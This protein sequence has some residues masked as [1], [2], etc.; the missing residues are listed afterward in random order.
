MIFCKCIVCFY[1]FFPFQYVFY[2]CSAWVVNSSN[3]FLFLPSEPIMNVS[4]TVS[5]MNL[6]EFNDSVTFTCSA[7]GTPLV[8]SL[9]NGSSEVTAANVQ[10]VNNTSVLIISNVTRYDTGPFSCSVKN[11]ISNGTSR[12]IPLD[13]SCKYSIILKCLIQLFPF[14]TNGI[15]Y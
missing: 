2:Q 15:Y 12:S 6:V 8:F 3:V 11:G 10:L 4:L 9:Y 7:H 13:I 5:T 14:Y 1:P